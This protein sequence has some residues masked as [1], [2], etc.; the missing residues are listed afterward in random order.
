MAMFCDNPE[1]PNHHESRY[2]DYLD[3]EL[4]GRRRRVERHKYAYR[5][6]IEDGREEIKTVWLCGICKGACDLIRFP[7]SGITAAPK[8]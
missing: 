4:A 1:C 3:L 8:G 2:D 5:R 7:H 6:E